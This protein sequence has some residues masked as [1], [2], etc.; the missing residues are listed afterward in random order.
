MGLKVLTLAMCSVTGKKVQV[1]STGERAKVLVAWGEGN[2]S[3]SLQFADGRTEQIRWSQDMQ[4][5]TVAGVELEEVDDF[6]VASAPVPLIS[7]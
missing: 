3:Y 4:G 2:P 1:H 6:L 5:H 7:V